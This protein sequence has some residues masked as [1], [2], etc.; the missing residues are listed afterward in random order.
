MKKITNNTHLEGYLYS[1]DLQLR[2]A[3]ENAKN[4]GTEFI[5][6]TL[7]ILTDDAGLNVVPVNFRYVTEKT[8]AGKTN[9]TFGV[10]KSIIESNGKTYQEAQTGALKIKVDTALGLND[11]YNAEGE[12]ITYKL[13]DGGFVHTVNVFADTRNQFEVDM[14]ITNVVRKEEDAEKGTPEIVLVKGATFN[15]MKSI[16][17][18]ELVVKDPAGMN[19]FEDLGASAAEPVFL[20]VWGHVACSTISTESVEESAFGEPAVKTSTRRL[21][22]WVITGASTEPYAFGDEE[23]LTGDEVKEAVAAR[24]VYLADVKKRHDEYLASKGTV[25]ATS[26][27]VATGGYSF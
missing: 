10:L 5:S 25:S 4:P 15:F 26:P 17:P 14:L 3:G 2:E 1:H 27:A 22:E 8:K 23:V 21:R 7:E 19:Y 12:L 24:E 18:I 6:G 20:K 11:F 16:L 9:A 13:N